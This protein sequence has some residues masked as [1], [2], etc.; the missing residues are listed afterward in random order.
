MAV[1][2]GLQ[3]TKSPGEAATVPGDGFPA[4]ADRVME[5]L[6]EHHCEGWLEGKNARDLR[7][8]HNRKWGHPQ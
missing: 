2:P 3:A 4:P 8:I 6:S 1:S 5:M 7:E